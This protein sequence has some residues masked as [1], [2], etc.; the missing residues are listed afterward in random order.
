MIISDLIYLGQLKIP[1]SGVVFLYLDEFPFC[2][3]GM[4]K[5]GSCLFSENLS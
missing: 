4:E 5:K 3:T 2:M 1:E